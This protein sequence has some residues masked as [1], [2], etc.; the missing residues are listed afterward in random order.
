MDDVGILLRGKSLEKLSLI[1]DKFNHCY[2]VNDFKK[3]LNF[4][5]KYIKGKNIIQYSNSMMDAMLVANNY[6][7][8]NISEV[9]LSF[10]KSMFK[11]KYNI[12]GEYKKRGVKRVIFLADQYEQDTRSI[13]NT[14]V[15]CIFYVSEVI[16]PKRIWM[17]GLEFYHSNYLV[18]KNLAHQLV[19][20]KK[21]KLIDSFIKI[22]KDHPSIEYNVIT[23]FK[24]LPRL[25]N[26]N[27][28]EV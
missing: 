17:I 18:K 7:K 22:V 27:I 8:F 11:N 3:E 5:G 12:V 26:L 2:I 9:N 4:V 21:I 25:D 15:C 19:K 24:N 1:I 28:M 14:G 20:T 13:H 6:K 23:Y 16:K 10:T